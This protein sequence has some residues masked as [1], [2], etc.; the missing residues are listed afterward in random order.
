MLLILT[1]CL[2]SAGPGGL[3]TPVNAQ[4]AGAG[5]VTLTVKQSILATNESLSQEAPALRDITCNYRLVPRKAT[6]PMPAGTV[7]SAYSF[8]IKGSAGKN[9]GPITFTDPG[10]YTYEIRHTTRPLPSYQF[11]Q[12]TH[13]VDVMVTAD[14]NATLVVSQECGS[15]AQEILYQHSY[16]SKQLETPKKPTKRPSKPKTPPVS[17]KPKTG[18]GAQILFYLLLLAVS[19]TFV[20]KTITLSS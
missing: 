6:T 20:R 3:M 13:I 12:R 17:V 15:K 19:T 8:A 4:A 16:N 1:I 5:N 18:D 10:L 2:M 14:M 11:D 7:A 9:I